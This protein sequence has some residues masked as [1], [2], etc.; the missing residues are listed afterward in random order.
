MTGVPPWM[1][2]SSSRRLEQEGEEKDL[3]C[4]WVQWGCMEL[5]V[6]W[7]RSQL[8]VYGSGLAGRPMRD[9]VVSI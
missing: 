6:G 8:R 5:S 3:P 2:Q 9:I 4:T 1:D 7:R